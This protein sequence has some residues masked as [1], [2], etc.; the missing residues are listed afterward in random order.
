MTLE[1]TLDPIPASDQQIRLRYDP[2]TDFGRRHRMGLRGKV[3]RPSPY[4]WVYDDIDQFMD[5]LPAV[6]LPSE[7]DM[8]E[9]HKQLDRFSKW[10]GTTREEIEKR[11]EALTRPAKPHPEIRHA[12]RKLEDG[13]VLEVERNDDGTITVTRRPAEGDE[14]E[15]KVKR[16]DDP[17]A[18]QESD[19]QAYE[20]LYPYGTYIDWKKWNKAYEEYQNSLNDYIDKLEEYD[21][22]PE[23]KRQW[24]SWNDYL[25]DE[26]GVELEEL[27]S[28]SES[29][30]SETSARESDPSPIQFDVGADGS[31]TMKSTRGSAQLQMTFESEA[32]LKQREPRL[33][34]LYL[35]LRAGLE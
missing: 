15:A 10:L 2:L 20:L 21:P 7:K 5:Q 9:Y 19:P 13:T 8:R 14:A 4:G 11:A 23:I 22:T 29:E 35:D 1:L 3:L 6:P 27:T 18:L 12:S 25:Q 34:E 26:Y 16:Y 28:P 17:K 32:D 31:I 24:R 33:H 30:A